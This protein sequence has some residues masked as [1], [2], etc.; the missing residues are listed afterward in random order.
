LDG[1]LVGAGSLKLAISFISASPPI[2][3]IDHL[4]QQLAKFG[5]KLERKVDKFKIPAILSP[6]V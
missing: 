5:Y 6:I 3:A 4:Q 2:F 1:A